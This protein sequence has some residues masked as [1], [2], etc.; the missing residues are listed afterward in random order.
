MLYKSVF[1]VRNEISE[2]VTNAINTILSK[3]S[4]S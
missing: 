3:L 4:K 1:M 2:H